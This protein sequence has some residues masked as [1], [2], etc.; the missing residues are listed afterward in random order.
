MFPIEV[1][2]NPVSLIRNEQNRNPFSSSNRKQIP[3]YVCKFNIK[4]EI[5]FSSSIPGIDFCAGVASI[6]HSY[7]SQTYK[8]D[9]PLDSDAVDILLG[10]HRANF[11]NHNSAV[12]FY[13]LDHMI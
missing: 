6:L 11:Y 2:L 3:I 9:I 13:P 1:S 5:E 4:I 7:F 8:F 12:D 10:F